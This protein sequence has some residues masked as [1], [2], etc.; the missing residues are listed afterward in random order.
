M[1]AAQMPHRGGGRGENGPFLSNE[2]GHCRSPEAE[3]LEANA[4]ALRLF[5]KAIELDPDIPSA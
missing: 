4:E 5:Y 1:S 3:T 2:S